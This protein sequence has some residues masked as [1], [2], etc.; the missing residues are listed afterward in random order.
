MRKRRYTVR[1][2]T[3]RKEREQKRTISIPKLNNSWKSGI[4][5]SWMLFTSELTF[6]GSHSNI[7]KEEVRRGRRERKRERER[8]RER[9]RCQKEKRQQNSGKRERKRKERGSM[10]LPLFSQREKRS[11]RPTKEYMIPGIRFGTLPSIPGNVV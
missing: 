7:C 9:E 6:R 4:D 2:R 11:A 3:S 1:D 5:S 8:E 10:F